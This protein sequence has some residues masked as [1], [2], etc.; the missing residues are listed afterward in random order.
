M[1]SRFPSRP[2]KRDQPNL[3]RCSIASIAN[4]SKIQMIVKSL[5][6][7]EREEVIRILRHL[8][9]W[10]IDYP[11]PAAAEARASPFGDKLDPYQHYVFDNIGKPSKTSS[12]GIVTL[13]SH[14][15]VSAGSVN[16]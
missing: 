6:I 15:M 1:G 10:P 8:Q 16:R 13:D 11:K 7:L 9:M 12:V 2:T 3:S 14:T 4:G 5:I